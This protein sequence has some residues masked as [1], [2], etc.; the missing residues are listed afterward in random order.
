M[1]IILSELLKRKGM[2]QAELA[3]LTQIR[4]S[5]VC[6]IY[7]NNSTFIKLEHIMRI[8]KVLDCG[9]EDLIIL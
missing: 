7:N 9:I 8:C 2:T 1:K 5:T 6:N 3:R 4:P